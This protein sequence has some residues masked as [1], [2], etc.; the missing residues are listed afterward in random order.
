[1]RAKLKF[2]A[3]K[4]ER[5]NNVRR[6]ATTTEAVALTSFIDIS[7]LAY[8]R[9]PMARNARVHIIPDPTHSLIALGELPLGFSVPKPG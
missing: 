7:S 2:K 6:I 4:E 8:P 3:D 5:A 1:M 9:L